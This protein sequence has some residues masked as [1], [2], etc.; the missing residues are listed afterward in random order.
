MLDRYMNYERE[1]VDIRR[2]PKKSK[3]S[4]QLLKFNIKI[5]ERGKIDITS[6]QIH[7]R[8]LSRLGTRT[9]IKSGGVKLVF[10]P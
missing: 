2:K 5:V 8:P 9:S 3:I 1:K 4:E 10:R 6:T 7:Y